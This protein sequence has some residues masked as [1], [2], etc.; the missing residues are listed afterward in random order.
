MRRRL[1]A[2]GSV[3]LILGLTACGG[4]GSEPTETDGATASGGTLT[5][6]PVVVAQPWDLKDAGL[7]NNTIY[8]QPVYDQ[9]F[10]I[11]PEAET[12]PNLA[13]EWAYDEALTTLTVTLREDVVFTDGTPFN[14]EAVAANLMHTKT[15][16][17]EA[18]NQLKSVDSVDVV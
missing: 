12:G 9:L 15:G 4:G 16:T 14:A 6:A 5:L 18:A 8:Y 7:G 1:L 13:T 17:N 2:A 11:S 3:A 10:R